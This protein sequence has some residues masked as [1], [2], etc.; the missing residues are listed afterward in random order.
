MRVHMCIYI[1][2]YICIVYSN[3]Q[4]CLYTYTSYVYGGAHIARC[5]QLTDALKVGGKPLKVGLNETANGMRLG[6]RPS[7]ELR[8]GGDLP[9]LQF[10]RLS[11]DLPSGHNMDFLGL[12]GGLLDPNSA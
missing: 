9:D 6:R 8:M 7:F 3:I 2:T 12:R 5:M 4:I 11:V 10:E 1:Y